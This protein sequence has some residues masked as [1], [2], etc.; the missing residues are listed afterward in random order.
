MVPQ[1]K[2]MQKCRDVVNFDTTSTAPRFSG[3]CLPRQQDAIVRSRIPAWVDPLLRVCYREGLLAEGAT[4]SASRSR[5]SQ[6]DPQVFNGRKA[7]PRG[8][9]VVLRGATKDAESAFFFVGSKMDHVRI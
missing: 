9:V 6:A 7:K 8:V 1:K 2:D 5:P 4:P 3:S